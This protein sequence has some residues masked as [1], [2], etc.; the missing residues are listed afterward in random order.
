MKIN[1]IRLPKKPLPKTIL[2]VEQDGKVLRYYFRTRR[3]MFIR[4][5]SGKP[6]RAFINLIKAVE[7]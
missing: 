6:A 5:M 7:P 2:T 1:K 3:K 4:E